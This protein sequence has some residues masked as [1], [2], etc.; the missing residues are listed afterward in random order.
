MMSTE[1]TDVK[2]VIKRPSLDKLI[3]VIESG[4]RVTSSRCTFLKWPCLIASILFMFWCIVSGSQIYHYV[5]AVLILCSVA[6][7]DQESGGDVIKAE[8]SV[9]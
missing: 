9:E 5:A 7:M 2:T 1:K 8:E 3:D 6:L 4:V